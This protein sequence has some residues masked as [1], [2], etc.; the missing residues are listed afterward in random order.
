VSVKVFAL[1]RQLTPR[2]V[3]APDRPIPRADFFRK[4]YRLD[5]VL[6]QGSCYKKRMI[7]KPQ[8]AD[9]IAALEAGD[10]SKAIRMAA[11]AIQGGLPFA[12]EALQTGFALGQASKGEP[13]PPEAMEFFRF[14]AA[15]P[16]AAD[17]FRSLR[18]GLGI[19]QA[20][21]AEIC[22]VSRA[23][24]SDWERGKAS[25]PAAAVQAL[26]GLAVARL[27]RGERTRLMGRDIA[28][29]RKALG[30]TQNDFAA[31]LGVS[32]IAIRKWERRGDVPLAASTVRRIQPRLDE[33]EARASPPS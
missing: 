24:V 14:L 29:M 4:L 16:G 26:Q 8:A 15:D 6:E 30:M 32:E 11:K 23:V 31:A 18:E 22:G 27:D 33:L 12:M 25:L 9:A 3:E 7:T 10:F 17:G 20:E 13:L 1:L 21:I 19:S 2:S 28:R 5:C